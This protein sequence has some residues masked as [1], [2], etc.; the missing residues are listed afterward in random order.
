MRWLT[1]VLSLCGVSSVALLALLVAVVYFNAVERAAAVVL[2]RGLRRIDDNSRQGQPAAY[3]VRSSA[4]GE[5]SVYRP[6]LL[7]LQACR[8]GCIGP[9]A[10]LC[11]HIWLAPYRAQ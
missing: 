8:G 7:R 10:S 6:V 4:D 1:L 11:T 9:D 3:T 5:P 2:R